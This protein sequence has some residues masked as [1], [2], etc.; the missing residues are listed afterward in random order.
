MDNDNNGALDF[1]EMLQ[2]LKE[3]GALDGF[4]VIME[5]DPFGEDETGAASSH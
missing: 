5:Q 3:L 2:A 1:S 4:Q